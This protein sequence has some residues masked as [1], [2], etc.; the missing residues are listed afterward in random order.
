MQAISVQ[1]TSPWHT[2]PISTSRCVLC[3]SHNFR[4][5]SAA[6]RQHVHWDARK[7]TCAHVYTY[8]HTHVSSSLPSC[9]PHE[10]DS[11]TRYCNPVDIRA[12]GSTRR[13][14]ICVGRT[15]S[16]AVSHRPRNLNLPTIS[17]NALKMRAFSI[18]IS[19]LHT[20][21]CAWQFPPYPSNRLTVD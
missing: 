14:E 7:I 20:T 4:Y 13:Y 8:R 9:F 10:P 16:G 2:S 5:D 15:T 11:T 1:D 18:R 21:Q 3:H 17:R 12:S 19:T 6:Q